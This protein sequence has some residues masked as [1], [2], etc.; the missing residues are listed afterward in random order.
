MNYVDRIHSNGMVHPE[1]PW[2]AENYIV[3]TD[4]KFVDYFADVLDE[5]TEKIVEAKP[6][7][8]GLSLHQTSTVSVT[9]VVER[10]REALPDIYIIVGG[11]SCYQHFVAQRIFPQADYVVVGRPIRNAPDPR[12]RAEEYQTRMAALCPAD[13]ITDPAGWHPALHE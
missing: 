8:V 9:R 4:Q 1:D 3:W 13:P 5:L 7:V 10:L 6:K 12:L 2:Q 11:M